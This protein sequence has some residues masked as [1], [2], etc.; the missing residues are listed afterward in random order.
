MNQ[1]DL[2]KLTNDTSSC[3]SLVNYDAW[4]EIASSDLFKASV[5]NRPS[6]ENKP[7]N[8]LNEFK[9]IVKSSSGKQK[10]FYWNHSFPSF[11][12]AFLDDHSIARRA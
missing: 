2:D 9:K 6:W 7:E 5:S 4:F 3:Q 1:L 11:D 10:Y 12:T 8:H